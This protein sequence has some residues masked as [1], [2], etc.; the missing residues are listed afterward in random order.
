[1]R[2]N[3]IVIGLLLLISMHSFANER[4]DIDGNGT[5]TVTDGVLALRCAA[6]L[7]IPYSCFP[8]ADIN[9]DG[10]TTVTDGVLILRRASGLDEPTP[11]PTPALPNLG[12]IA[13][14]VSE[15]PSIYTV[16]GPPPIMSLWRVNT[17]GSGLER[18]ASDVQR[19]RSHGDVQWSPDGSLITYRAKNE[20]EAT[21]NIID[22]HGLLIAKTNSGGFES[23]RW[24]S[25]SDSLLFSRYVDGIYTFDL[26]ATEENLLTTIGY[27]YDHS[28]S[29]S[30]DGKQLAFVH[31]E[32]G[33]YYYIRILNSDL[34]ISEVDNFNSH[35]GS[36]WDEDL[37]VVW[38]SNQV[39]AHKL[40]YK[41]IVF[42][43]AITHSSRMVYKGND[44]SAKDIVLSPDKK[45]ILHYV[46]NILNVLNV[47][48]EIDTVYNAEQYIGDIDWANN[49]SAIV[50]S[51]SFYP[52]LYYYNRSNDTTFQI[53]LAIPLERDGDELDIEAIDFN[54]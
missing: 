33:T 45:E 47:E 2:F 9:N 22:S 14:I 7:D 20:I 44:Y 51:S 52:E 34:T 27:T 54:G 43:N 25:L 31:H 8:D 12:T 40:D 30:P 23:A 18:L 11:I 37:E 26:S 53:P 17:D 50:Y 19:Y 38:L 5:I 16:D 49:G 48:T 21:H 29:Y 3:L 15:K 6:G 39:I 10:N 46:D 13:L 4:G 32:A 24:N 41:N 42:V 35:G 36:G 1:M 28:P